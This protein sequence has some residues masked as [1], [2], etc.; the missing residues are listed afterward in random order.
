MSAIYHDL[1]P[2]CAQWVENLVTA[3]HLP[4]G[5]V[6]CGDIRELDPAAVDGP[7]QRHFFAGI[8]GWAYACRLAGV[9]DDADLWTGSCPCQPFSKAG[10]HRATDDD[11]N[12][13]PAWAELVRACRPAVVVG[14]QVAGA[15]ALAW[16]DMV[17]DDLE[18]EGYTCWAAIISASAVGALHER[19]RLYWVAYADGIQH[20]YGRPGEVYDAQGAHRV[21]HRPGAWPVAEIRWVRCADGRRRATQPGLEPVVDGVP[22]GVDQLRA[23][24]NA[25]V[26]QVAEAFLRT[27]LAEE[28]SA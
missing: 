3:G 7:G 2:Y 4:A 8:A 19:A 12:L 18:R 14:E 1:D 22:G 15:A 23:Y 17:A 21:E 10:L 25:I 9:P 5:E 11:R 20:A 6:I 16:W 27:V 13:W 26:P 24:G 28:V